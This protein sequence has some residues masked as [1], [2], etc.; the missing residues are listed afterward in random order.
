MEPT[1]GIVTLFGDVVL[2][3][4]DQLQL[5]LPLN[6]CMLAVLDHVVN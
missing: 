4:H 6:V 2:L 1:E 5:G 3:L